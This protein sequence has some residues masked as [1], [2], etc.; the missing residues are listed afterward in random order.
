MTVANIKELDKS[1]L[2][3]ARIRDEIKDTTRAIIHHELVKSERD[4]VLFINNIHVSRFPMLKPD[5]N[6]PIRAN[7]VNITD[8]VSTVLSIAEI[9]DQVLCFLLP[10]ELYIL[11]RVTQRFEVIVTEGFTRSTLVKY[12]NDDRRGSKLKDERTNFALYRKVLLSYCASGAEKRPRV[13][14]MLSLAAHYN[15]V[16]DS[17][18]AHM[19]MYMGRSSIFRRSIHI[20]Y[21]FAYHATSGHFVRLRDLNLYIISNLGTVYSDMTHERL[22]KK[23]DY[24]VIDYD[25]DDAVS[26]LNYEEFNLLEMSRVTDIVQPDDKVYVITKTRI[27]P[28]YQNFNIF[29]CDPLEKPVDGWF[30]GSSATPATVANIPTNGCPLFDY[31]LQRLQ[32]LSKERSIKPPVKSFSYNMKFNVHA[33]RVQSL[34]VK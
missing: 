21:A 25:D 23:Y 7:D 4:R 14:S 1:N 10:H 29:Y 9:A 24:D 3:M 30:D 34:I 5:Y 15:N 31:Y 16:S 6:Q 22:V 20:D 12:T 28:F 32:A 19:S 33:A 26:Y 8:V 27:V 2:K 11:T 17:A 18:R 13:H